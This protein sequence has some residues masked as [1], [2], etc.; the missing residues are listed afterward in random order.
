MTKNERRF[1]TRHQCAW[2][3]QPLDKDWCGAIWDKCSAETRTKR[4]A[5]CLKTYKPRKIK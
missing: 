5:E 3:D 4:Q 2:C 1:L